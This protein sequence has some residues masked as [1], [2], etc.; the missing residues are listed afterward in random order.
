MEVSRG[1]FCVGGGVWKFF[2]GEWGWVGKG[3][4]IFWMSRWTFSMAEWGWVGV[5][6][7]MFWVDG[8][9]LTFFMG[10]WEVGGGWWG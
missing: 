10:Y 6:R 9:G 2:M 3:E 8:V 4:G 5:D 7:G 1:I